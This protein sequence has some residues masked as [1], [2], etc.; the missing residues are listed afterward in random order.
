MLCFDFAD[1]PERGEG[2]YAHEN[3]CHVVCA[4]KAAQ[5]EDDARQQKEPPALLAPMIFGFDD[6]GVKKSN[7]EKGA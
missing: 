3:A 1:A 4:K 2:H 6:E 5:E 7:G